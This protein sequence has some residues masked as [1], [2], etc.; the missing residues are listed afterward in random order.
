MGLFKNVGKKVVEK[1][2]GKMFVSEGVKGI[3]CPIDSLD[4]TLKDIRDEETSASS[5]A[6]KRSR[7]TKDS[8]D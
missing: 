3:V 2:M 7:S 5:S 8:D 6:D 1:T 4:E